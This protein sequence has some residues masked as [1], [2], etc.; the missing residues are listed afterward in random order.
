MDAAVVMSLLGTAAMVCDLAWPRG[1]DVF[2][3]SSSLFSMGRSRSSSLQLGVLGGW[4]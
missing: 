1:R 4:V 3:V 2:M